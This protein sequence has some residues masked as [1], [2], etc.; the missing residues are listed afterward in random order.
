MFIFITKSRGND[1]EMTDESAAV[2]LPDSNKQEALDSEVKPD[3]MQGEQ[4]WPTEH[5]IKNAIAG[6]Y[7]YLF[8]T[9][10]Y[11]IYIYQKLKIEKKEL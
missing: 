9:F 6:K 3:P 5:D 7:V 2:F 11:I 4:T 10:I 8:L 1:V